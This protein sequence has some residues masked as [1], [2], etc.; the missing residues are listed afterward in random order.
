MGVHLVGGER[1]REMV[2]RDWRV[3]GGLQVE[4]CA[5]FERLGSFEELESLKSIG[6]FELM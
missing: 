6:S 3:L 2:V 1:E 4:S 5:S